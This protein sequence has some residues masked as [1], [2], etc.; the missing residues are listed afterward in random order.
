M[1]LETFKRDHLIPCT[2]PIIEHILDEYLSMEID[3]ASAMQGLHHLA[4]SC[5]CFP[6]TTSSEIR[7]ANYMSYVS[8]ICSPE[9]KEQSRALDNLREFFA[10]PRNKFPLEWV[11]RQ[12]RTLHPDFY[13]PKEIA[14]MIEI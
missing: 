9:A 6:S 1:D 13:A 8:G 4:I 5:G 12:L 10:S 14:I 2:K 7:F 11:P 3:S